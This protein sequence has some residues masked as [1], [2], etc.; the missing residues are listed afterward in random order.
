MQTT[1]N[2][3]SLTCDVWTAPHG[4][5][6]SYLAVTAHWFHPDS[7]LM[8]KRTIDFKL[9]GYPHTGANLL[10][11]LLDVM[12]EYKIDDKVFSM[13][14]DNAS[15]NTNAINRMKLRLKPILD[16]DFFHTRC[17]AHIINISVQAGLQVCDDLRTKFKN[18]LTTIYGTSN[19]R[20]ANYRFFC[21]QCNEPCLGPNFD[22]RWNSTCFMFES[23]LRQKLTLNAFNEILVEKRRSVSIPESDWNLLQ[24]LTHFLQI[25]KEAT[26]LLSGVYYPTSPLVLNQFFL[27]TEKMANFEYSSITLFQNM[28]IA[29]KSKFLKYF[30]EL[31]LVFTCAAALN[32]TINVGGVNVLMGQIYENLGLSELEPNF[33]QNQVFKFNDSF[34]K[35]FEMYAT[36][37]GQPS[38]VIVDHIRRGMAGSSSSGRNVNINLYNTLMEDATKRQRTSAPSSELG[39]YMAT[40]FLAHFTVEEFQNFDILAWWKEK[41]VQFPILAAMARDLLTVQASTVASESAFSFSGRVITERRSKLT[42]ES[43]EVC[44]CLKDYL[45]DVERIQNC[46][47]LE[48]PLL[49]PVEEYIHEE[50]VAMGIS[51]PTTEVDE[52][53][54]EEFSD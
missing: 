54:I 19:Q 23:I 46:V 30:R 33:V 43:M 22:T 51:P 18:L 52:G 49:P 15:N 4:N 26:S 53:E 12:A 6:N 48:G 39:N 35:L 27:M 47:S 36:K 38:N 3:I 41:E 20:Q 40:N 31:P 29:M 45:D 13:S 14:L 2:S 16:D 37:Y 8:M 44:V 42:A 1:K 10:K 11:I 17:I 9:F 21:A 5:E 28:V 32:P 34:K 50:E 24:E 7:W 25:F